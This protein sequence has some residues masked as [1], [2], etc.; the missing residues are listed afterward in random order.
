MSETRYNAIR[1]DTTRHVTIQL[2]ICGTKVVVDITHRF[3]MGGK[4]GAC[5]FKICPFGG[6]QIGCAGVSVLL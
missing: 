2:E 3:Y 6:P 5:F 1:Y 4:T